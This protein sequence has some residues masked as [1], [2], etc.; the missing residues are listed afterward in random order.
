[1][2]DMEHIAPITVEEAERR[3]R[4]LRAEAARE[5]FAGLGRAMRRGFAGLFAGQDKSAHA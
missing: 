5:M 4:E 2:T 3:A 1:M